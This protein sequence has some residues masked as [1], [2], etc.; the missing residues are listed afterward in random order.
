MS[1]ELRSFKCFPVNLNEEKLN[2]EISNP[3]GKTKYDHFSKETVKNKLTDG[4]M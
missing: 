1:Y 3:I 2:I 4:W